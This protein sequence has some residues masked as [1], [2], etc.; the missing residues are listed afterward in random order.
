VNRREFF[1]FKSVR[2]DLVLCLIIS[3]SLVTFD[4]FIAVAYRDFYHS[5]ILP[6]SQGLV[7]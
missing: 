7:F 2:R 6:S 5:W 1:E 4:K 3:G